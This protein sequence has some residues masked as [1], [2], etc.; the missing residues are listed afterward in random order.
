MCGAHYGASLGLRRARMRWR[1]PTEDGAAAAAGSAHR[2]SALGRDGQPEGSE[3][4]AH[5]A[6]QPSRGYGDGWVR[7]R[8]CSVVRVSVAQDNEFLREQSRTMC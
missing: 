6:P 4:D 7:S 1:R 5:P 2:A 3:P 8:G